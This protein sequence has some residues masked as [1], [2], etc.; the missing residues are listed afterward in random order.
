ASVCKFTLDDPI[1][2]SYA[3]GGDES[4]IPELDGK[5]APATQ[6][7]EP[8]AWSGDEPVFS[9]VQWH[10]STGRVTGWFD[11]RLGRSADVDRGWS[12]ILALLWMFYR[13]ALSSGSQP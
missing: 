7:A 2:R 1:P 6:C 10:D 3:I 8:I 11:S 13:V 4:S 5:Y 12:R 9:C